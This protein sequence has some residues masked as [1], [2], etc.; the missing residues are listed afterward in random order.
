MVPANCSRC[1]GTHSVETYPSINTA[2]DPT[3]KARVR[4]GSLFVWECPY[5]GTRN[6]L[7]YE[8]LY[9]DPAERLMVWLLP[10]DAL[11]PAAVADAVK[12]LD[13]YTLRLV[14]EVGD[15]VEKVNIHAAGLDDVLVEMCK[16]VTRMELSEKQ[17]S[18]VEA[19]LKFY[20]LDGPDNDLLFSFPQDGEMKVVNVGFHVYEDARGILGRHPSVRPEPGFAQVDAAWLGQYFR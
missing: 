5:C 8:T 4:D 2:L 14:R 18:V 16:Y 1:G 17:G 9:H 11:P 3:L 10:G 6:L 19:P 7:K 15:L 20:K 13:G 12:E